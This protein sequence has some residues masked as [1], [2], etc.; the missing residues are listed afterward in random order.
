MN[1]KNQFYECARELA[2]FLGLDDP[3]ITPAMDVASASD[4]A[5]SASLSASFMAPM[6]KFSVT[7]SPCGSQLFAPSTLYLQF[8]PAFDEFSFPILSYDLMAHIVSAADDFRAQVFSHVESDERLCACFAEYRKFFGK[9][10]GEICELFASVERTQCLLDGIRA[11]AHD[12]GG[13]EFTEELS[14]LV[15]RMTDLYVSIQLMKYT[16][17]P[18]LSF[19]SG[20]I[21]RARRKYGKMKKRTNYESRLNSFLQSLPKGAEYRAIPSEAFGYADMRTYLSNGAELGIFLIGYAIGTVLMLPLFVLLYMGFAYASSFDAIYYTGLDPYNIAFAALPSTLMGIVI[22]YYLRLPICKIIHR[23][24]LKKAMQALE[25]ASSKKTDRFM[26]GFFN[27][28]LCLSILVTALMANTGIVVTEQGVID[29]GGYFALR[30]TLYPWEDIDSIWLI[31]GR[32]NGLGKWVDAESYVILLKNGDKIDMYEY[33]EPK[34]V[35]DGALTYLEER[36]GEVQKAR[37][38]A[39]ILLNRDK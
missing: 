13:F 10:Y 16:S 5:D 38:E 15:T 24:R 23:K 20:N 21:D 39:D 6:F 34:D 7:L 30:G 36:L 33:T 3:V 29:R 22:S 25:L 32:E 12:I 19:L 4:D 37:S 18:Y 26:R 17:E 27:V 28:I 8:Y 1:F 14:D 9:Y 31:E 11:E 35:Q 2:D